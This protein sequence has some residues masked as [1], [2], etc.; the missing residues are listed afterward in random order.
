MRT[1][2][3]AMFFWPVTVLTLPMLNVLAKTENFSVDTVWFQIAINV[4]FTVWSF[5]GIAWSESC[6]LLRFVVADR[7]C[8]RRLGS[9]GQ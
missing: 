6:P 3:L 1:H 8:S 2:R 5:A 7:F 9:I 4:F